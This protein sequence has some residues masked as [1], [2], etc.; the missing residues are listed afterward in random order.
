MKNIVVKLERS[1]VKVL[2]QALTYYA[3]KVEHIAQFAPPDYAKDKT[4][5]TKIVID[6]SILLTLNV[7]DDEAAIPSLEGIGLSLICCVEQQKML[8]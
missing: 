2:L 1:N 6:P 3:A 8:L 4:G 7:T 5:A